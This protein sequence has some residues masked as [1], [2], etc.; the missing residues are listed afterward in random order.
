MAKLK[1]RRVEVAVAQEG[2]VTECVHRC[3]VA[4]AYR[5]GCKHLHA[6]FEPQ[7]ST[8]MASIKYLLRPRDRD[9]YEPVSSALKL[10]LAIVGNPAE[11][12]T[13]IHLS[14][15]FISGQVIILRSTQPFSIVKF[16]THD[17]DLV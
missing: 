3:A 15:C 10:I 2:M 9:Y 12:S 16:D 11:H 5:I 6:L 14:I 1:A 4:L 17:C 8:V 7:K 13:R